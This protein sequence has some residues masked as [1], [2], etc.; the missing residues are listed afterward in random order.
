VGEEPLG[1]QRGD[2]LGDQGAELKAAGVA[3]GLFEVRNP[4]RHGDFLVQ[5]IAI[6]PGKFALGAFVHSH[7]HSGDPGGRPSLELPLQAPSRAYL[8]LE[9][10]LSWSGA[11]IRKG[12]IAVEIGSA[13]GGA[14]FA[15][16]E[17]GLEVVGIDPA[18]MAPHVFQNPNFKHIRRPVAQVPREE[19]PEKVQWVLLDMNVEPNISLYAVDRLATRLMDSL[20]G[21]F[22]TVKLNQWAFAD[23]IPYFMEHVK[24]I[25]MVRVKAAQL[26]YHRQEILIYGLTRR[27]LATQK[28]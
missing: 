14:S 15:L 26:A 22:L 7:F 25:G 4:P 10:A 9:H 21:V 6:D 1:Y 3:E 5:F 13:P 18:E 20:H 19:L 28:Y 27:G 17:R 16:L 8:K 24:A 23:E 11:P 12:D 2:W